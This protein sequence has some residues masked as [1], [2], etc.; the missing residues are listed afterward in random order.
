MLLNDTQWQDKKQWTHS[1]IQEI[2]FKQK[3]RLVTVQAIKDMKFAQ[4]GGGI[5]I[6][7]DALRCDW[8]RS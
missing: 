6:L 5:S 4:G 3:R 2:P 8:M 7:G 1:E